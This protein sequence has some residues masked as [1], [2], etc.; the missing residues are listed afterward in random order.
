MTVAVGRTDGSVFVVRLG[1][2]YLTNF[3]LAKNRDEDNDDDYN[4]QRTEGAGTARQLRDDMPRTDDDESSVPF[5]IRHQFL[6]SDRGEPIRGLVYHDTIE[7]NNGERD[8][9]IIC[10]VAGTSGDIIVWNLPLH[11]EE[12]DAD[13]GGVTQAAVLGGVHN[14]RIVSLRTMILKYQDDG[15]DERDVLFSASEDG[16]FALWD[17]DNGELIFSFRCA[18]ADTGKITCA[19]VYNP[20]SWDDGYGDGDHRGNNDVIFLGT[21][22]GYVFGYAVQEL[23]PSCFETDDNTTVRSANASPSIRFR[24]H[25]TESGK[26]EAITAIKCGGI[27]T[28]PTTSRSPNP[29]L[30]SSILLTGGEDGSV[31]QW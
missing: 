22:G 31:K 8:G 6:A 17:L 1:D 30:S 5:V 19:D 4:E 21:S 18:S 27:G 24:A 3:V 2:E 29:A 23:L 20:S 28:I 26:G 15:M 14:D 10:T 11:E 7:G 13:V 12:N 25:G 16:T 9:G